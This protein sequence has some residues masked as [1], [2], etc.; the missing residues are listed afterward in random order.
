MV[1]LFEFLALD[2]GDITVLQVVHTLIEYFRNI[3]TTEMAIKA[4]VVYIVFHYFQEV[5]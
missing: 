1:F 3:S 2:D 4:I 5:K